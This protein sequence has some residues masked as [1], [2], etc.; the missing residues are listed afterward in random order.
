MLDSFLNKIYL[1]WWSGDKKVGPHKKVLLSR[2]CEIFGDM[3]YDLRW[4]LK[5][6]HKNGQ[7]SHAVTIS[8]RANKWDV[9]RCIKRIEREII[10]GKIKQLIEDN[11]STISVK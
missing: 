8:E 11:M 3:V 10:P 1:Y 4:K 7:T 2:N 5:Y 9:R 6:I